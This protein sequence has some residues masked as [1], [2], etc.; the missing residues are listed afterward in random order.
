MFIINADSI[1]MLNNV[2]MARCLTV[3]NITLQ[4]V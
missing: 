1:I 2:M 3:D 4:L